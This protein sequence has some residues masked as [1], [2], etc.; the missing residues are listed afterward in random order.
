VTFG[1]INNSCRG[2]EKKGRKE[3][4]ITQQK[5]G[6]KLSG[7]EEMRTIAKHLACGGY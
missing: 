4:G 1:K 3:N 7:L 5:R 6:T 2:R